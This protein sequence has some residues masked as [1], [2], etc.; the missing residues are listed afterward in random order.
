MEKA[1]AIDH[2][3]GRHAGDHGNLCVR[4][5]VGAKVGAACGV[6]GVGIAIPGRWGKSCATAAGSARKSVSTSKN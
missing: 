5:S 2:F 1:P 6:S 3:V 4:G